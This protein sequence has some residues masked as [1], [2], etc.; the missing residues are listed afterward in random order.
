MTKVVNIRMVNRRR[1]YFDIYIGRELYYPNA[2]FSQSKWANPFRVKI[3]GR[4]KSLELYEK[5]IRNTPRLWNALDELEG[6]ILGDW[7]KPKPC[8]GDILIKLLKEKKRKIKMENLIKKKEWKE[9][10]EEV[11]ETDK[12]GANRFNFNFFQVDIEIPKKEDEEI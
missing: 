9:I 8:H 1:P 5:H 7:C 10:Q 2:R 3:Y 4:K 6:K 11:K 12:K